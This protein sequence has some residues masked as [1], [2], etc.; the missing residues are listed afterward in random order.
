MFR[1]VEC[2][3][4]SASSVA[5]GFASATAAFAARAA[6][7]AITSAATAAATAATIT[8]DRHADDH[9]LHRAHDRPDADHHR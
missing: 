4:Y 2:G 8:V 6:I 3:D 9:R 5:F 7:A 1:S